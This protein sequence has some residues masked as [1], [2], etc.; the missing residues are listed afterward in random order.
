MTS[1][2]EYKAPQVLFVGRAV[3]LLQ[4]QTDGANQ[5]RSAYQ[6]VVAARSSKKKAKKAVK[7]PVKKGIKKTKKR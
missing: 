3:D 6:R 2:V 7:K 4:R 5:D 1:S